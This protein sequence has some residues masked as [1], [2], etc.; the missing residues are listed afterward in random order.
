[1]KRF[2]PLTLIL[3]AIVAR[4]SAAEPDAV[5]SPIS[6]FVTQYCVD[7]HNGEEKTADLPLDLFS[8]EKVAAHR[9][10]WE[11]V[12]RRLRTRQMPPPDA[13]RPDEKTY[14]TV[15]AH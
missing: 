8:G 3:L 5:P 7:C 4:L 11:Q 9:E 10:D 13:K 2:L 14:Q 15:V 6:E 1:M 12:I